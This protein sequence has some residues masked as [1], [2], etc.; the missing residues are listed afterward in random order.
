MRLL[1]LNRVLITTKRPKARA[2]RRAARRNHVVL[3]LIEPDRVTVA[4]AVRQEH[5]VRATGFRRHVTAWYAPR[6][7]FQ[8]LAARTARDRRLAAMAPRTI[9]AF[10]V[11]CDLS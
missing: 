9:E 11:R 3:W 5:L 8:R 1:R 4:E 2:L 6:S 7:V 10:S